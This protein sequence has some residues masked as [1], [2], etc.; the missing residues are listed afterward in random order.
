[1]RIWRRISVEFCPHSGNNST[2]KISIAAIAVAVA[3]CFPVGALAVPGDLDPTF[4]EDGLARAWFTGKQAPQ[5]PP[6]DSAAIDVARQPDGKLVALGTSGYV[7]PVHCNRHLGCPSRSYLALARFTPDGA[8]DPSFGDSGQL[9]L[10]HEGL[11]G[12]GVAVQSDGRIIVAGPTSIPG[13]EGGSAA[14]VLRL[15]PDG[16]IDRSYGDG[17]VALVTLETG[18]DPAAMALDGEDRVVLLGTSFDASTRDDF[19][20]ARLSVDGALDQ[21]FAGD[22]VTVTSDP[23]DQRGSALALGPGN[24]ITVSGTTFIVEP[25]NLEV[26]TAR[27]TSDGELDPTFDGDGKATFDRTDTDGFV[28]EVDDMILDSQNRV[29]V[30]GMS[31]LRTAAGSG[32]LLLRLTPEGGLD[33]TLAGRGWDILLPTPPGAALP[34]PSQHFNLAEQADG[35]IVMAGI[36]SQLGRL[37]PD[38]SVDRSFSGDGWTQ[39][40][41]EGYPAYNDVMALPGG[42]ILAAGGGSG[43]LR[44]GFR[45]PGM[46]LA[47]F[48]VSDGPPDADADGV[49][50]PSDRC[51]DR[52]GARSGCPVHLRAVRLGVLRERWLVVRIDAEN[53]GCATGDSALFR[54]RRGKDERVSD[55]NFRYR[56][57][58][59]EPGRYYTRVFKKFNPEYGHCKRAVSPTVRVPPAR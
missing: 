8:L 55:D 7:S 48:L 24:A 38:S 14:Y 31:Y 21:S 32:T 44:G 45:G 3:L 27:Y 9:E 17:G 35:R 5:F 36:G 53:L 11:R 16:D 15:T 42:G 10:N 28:Y 41:A 57:G 2:P 30:V 23:G 56:L 52:Y 59:L 51:P 43:G 13:A 34:G 6:T 29:L 58:R 22:G 19:A 40:G 33:T 50:D 47:R 54:K 26:L 46:V 12:V 39:A 25:R 37:N 18:F 4:S 1:V 49:L 20:L